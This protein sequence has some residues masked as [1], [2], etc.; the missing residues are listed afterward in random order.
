M[1]KTSHPYEDLA[2]AVVLQALKDYSSE[3]YRKEVETF[4]KSQWYEAL[5][6]LP[7]DVILK[8]AHSGVKPKSIMSAGMSDE[9]RDCL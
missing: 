7:S 9:K 8:I 1:N 6:D 2:N 4:F 3:R 5:T